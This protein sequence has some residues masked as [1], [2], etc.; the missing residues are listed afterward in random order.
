MEKGDYSAVFTTP[1]QLLSPASYFWHKIA[2]EA[3]TGQWASRI[4]CFVVDEGHLVWRWGWTL[5]RKT[6]L[7][8][9]TLRSYF[10]DVPFL[11]MSATLAPNVRAYVHKVLDLHRPTILVRRS[12]ARRNLDIHVVPIRESLGNFSSLDF[13]IDQLKT[14]KG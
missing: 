5:F 10:E 13:L 2:P 9:G 6:Y 14:Q 12:I 7:Q 11:V 1:E 3:K 8:I 4:I